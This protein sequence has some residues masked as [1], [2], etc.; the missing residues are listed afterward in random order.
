MDSMKRQKGMTLE[1]K[2]PR[3]EGVQYATK[4]EQRVITNSSRKNEEDEPKQKQSPVVYVTDSG[5]KV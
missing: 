3:L 1:D 4:E 2:P 5:S